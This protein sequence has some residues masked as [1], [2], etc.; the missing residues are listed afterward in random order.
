MKKVIA[1]VGLVLSINLSYAQIPKTNIV[2]HFTNSNCSVC[3]NNNPGIYTTLN[4][5]PNV[6][7]ISFHP[8]SPY[9]ACVFSMANPVENDARTN[10]YTIYG[11][12]P[13]LIVNGVLTSTA[14]L[15][16]A[17]TALNSGTTNFSL[18]TTQQFVTTDSI[19]VKVVIKKVATD[20]ATQAFLFVGAKQDTVNQTTSNGEPVHYNVFRKSLSATSGDMINLPLNINDSIVVNYSYKVL[21]TW[22]STGMQTIAILQDATKQVINASESTNIMSV[23]THVAERYNEVAT[24]FPNPCS[25]FISITSDEEFTQYEIRSIQG[26]LVAEGKIL[27]S[28]ISVAQIASG[29]YILKLSSNHTINMS[30]IQILK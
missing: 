10:Y 3:A 12:T 21:P 19:V 25:D 27:H 14:N 16:S 17:L 30:K 11:S 2:E 13:R 7:H 22:N 8:S 15:N 29:N 28:R 23:P 1:L 20:T 4:S 5:N 24:L 26:S 18:T 6:L 9:A